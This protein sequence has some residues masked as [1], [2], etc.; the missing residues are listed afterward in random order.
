[1][2]LLDRLPRV[3]DELTCDGW[4]ISVLTVEE[5]RIISLRL[6]RITE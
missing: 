4:R 2:S 5:R 1:M 6:S 3:G